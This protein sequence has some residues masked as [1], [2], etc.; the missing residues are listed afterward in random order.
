MS[1]ISSQPASQL[2]NTFRKSLRT[3]MRIA[4]K[5]IIAAAIN[6]AELAFRKVSPRHR[7]SHAV[8]EDDVELC[9]EEGQT[10][11]I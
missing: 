11:S 8:G 3:D 9:R 6:V 5:E 4:D 7:F 10:M 1:P 2:A